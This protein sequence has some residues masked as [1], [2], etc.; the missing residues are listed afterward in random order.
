METGV[1]KAKEKEK[2]D[3]KGKG[4]G[5][6]SSPFFWRGSRLKVIEQCRRISQSMF[7][8]VSCPFTNI[9][10]CRYRNTRSVYDFA[11]SMNYIP[12][13]IGYPI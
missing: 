8:E 1:E 12:C 3:G 13:H 9:R 5:T 4:K 2:V 10:V 7:V 6:K 11:A